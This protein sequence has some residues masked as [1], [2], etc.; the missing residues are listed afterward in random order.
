MTGFA[1]VEERF[2]RLCSMCGAEFV[3]GSR[4]KHRCNPCQALVI[5]QRTEK[6]NAARRAQRLKQKKPLDSVNN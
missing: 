4:T 1:F 6:Q 2:T 5:C 3:T